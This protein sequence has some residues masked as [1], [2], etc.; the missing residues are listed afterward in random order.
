MGDYGCCGGFCVPPTDEYNLYDCTVSYYYDCAETI[1][2]G[3]KFNSTLNGE[4][5]GDCPASGDCAGTN[6]DGF[7][8]MSILTLGS[9]L[10]CI[11]VCMRLN[12]IQKRKE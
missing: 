2:T 1:Y 7:W 4:C 12:C 3:Q 5:L 10:L 8:A 9:I 11:C 6:F